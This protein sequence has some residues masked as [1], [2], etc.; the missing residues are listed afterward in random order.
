MTNPFSHLFRIFLCLA[1]TSCAVNKKPSIAT[2]GVTE[3]DSLGLTTEGG[4]IIQY[5]DTRKND[6]GENFEVVAIPS[7]WDKSIQKAYFHPTSSAQPRPLI[8]SLHTWSGSYEQT[9]PLAEISQ[10]L[11]LNYIHP[12]FRGPNWT[13]DACCSGLALNDIDDA[14][15]YALDHSNV[16]EDHIYVIGVSGGGYATLS[17]FMKS[18]HPIRKFSAWA[19]ITDLAAWYNESIIRNNPYA[20]HILKCT[21]ATDELIDSLA[22][23]KSPLYWT[24]PKTKLTESDLKIYAGIYDGIQGSVPITH[25]INFYNKVLSDIGVSD[26]SKYVSD[27]EKLRLLEYRKPLG[28]FG[29]IADRDICLLKQSGNIQLIIFEGNHEMLPEYA[30]HELLDTH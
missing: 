21:G 18:R 22:Q 6:W 13:I 2:T 15:Q 8:V 10:S 16:A 19:S 27:A 20:S 5:D 17:T 14:I 26:S 3:T 23:Q 4:K 28:N 25:S 1:L 12:D 24:T 9:D 11:D 29:K 30:L 7:S